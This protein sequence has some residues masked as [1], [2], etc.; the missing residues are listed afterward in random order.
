MVRGKKADT[1]SFHN[2]FILLARY[3]H[4]APT[5]VF[6]KSNVPVLLRMEQ[7]GLIP[8]IMVTKLVRSV[9]SQ[10]ESTEVLTATHYYPA[11]LKKPQLLDVPELLLL[12]ALSIESWDIDSRGHLC[13]YI[14]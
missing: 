11:S 13:C 10:H 8:T 7:K 12:L 2:N 6:Q 4:S 5:L 9:L 3:V 14:A 1:R